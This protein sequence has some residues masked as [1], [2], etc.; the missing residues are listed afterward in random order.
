M[1]EN[2]TP[3]TLRTPEN[4]PIPGGGSWRWTPQG[5]VSNDPAPQPAPEPEE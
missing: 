3:T 4:T 2:T 5:W 1:A